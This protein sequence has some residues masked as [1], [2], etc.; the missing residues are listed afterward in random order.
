VGHNKQIIAELP[1]SF[2]KKF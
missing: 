1:I 2:R